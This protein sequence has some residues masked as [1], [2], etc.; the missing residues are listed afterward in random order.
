MQPI[1]YVF[2]IAYAVGP[3]L[4]SSYQLYLKF[5]WW[6]DMLHGFAGVIFAILGAY[7]PRILSKDKKC[8]VALG[9]VMAFSFSLAIAG[10][11][12]FI[13]FG[14]DSIFGTDMQKDTLITDMR[15]SYLLGQIVKGVDGVLGPTGAIDKTVIYYPDGTTSVIAGGYL[16]IGLL[17]SMHDMLI[18]TLGA[19][20]YVV[21]YVVFKGKKFVLVP[22]E[23]TTPTINEEPNT[24][25]LLEEV[26]SADVNHTP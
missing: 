1:L 23:K 7:L 17:D 25:L 2:V 20:I 4:G 22:V 13:E 18:E 5:D 16:D 8:S 6:D 10:V 11:W 21:I 26:A 15:P 19:L 24:E 3:L 14:L 9:A 12:E